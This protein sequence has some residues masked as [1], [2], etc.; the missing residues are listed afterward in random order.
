MVLRKNYWPLCIWLARCPLCI[1]RTSD[2]SPSSFLSDMYILS[3]IR[4][5]TLSLIKY[6]RLD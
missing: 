6:I 1:L 3:P 2:F 4:F 5:A